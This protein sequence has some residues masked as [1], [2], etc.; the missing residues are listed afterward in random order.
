MLH[1]VGQLGPEFDKGV[2]IKLEGTLQPVEIFR[3]YGQWS[4]T[5]ENGQKNHGR[6]NPVT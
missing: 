1:A 5:L 6:K 4:R 3:S 2:L